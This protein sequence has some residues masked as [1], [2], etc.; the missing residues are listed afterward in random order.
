[1]HPVILK[2]DTCLSCCFSVYIAEGLVDEG[3]VMWGV[4]RVIGISLPL[5]INI[6]L[7]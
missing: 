5:I 1:M 4:V 6:G 3:G 7:E 2:L